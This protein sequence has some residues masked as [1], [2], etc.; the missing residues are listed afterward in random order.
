[1]LQRCQLGSPAALLRIV[2]PSSNCFLIVERGVAM[3]NVPQKRPL[4]A[5]LGN[6]S[7]V[8]RQNWSGVA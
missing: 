3:H 5:A 2:V 4:A 6:C 1:M 8:V 7:A